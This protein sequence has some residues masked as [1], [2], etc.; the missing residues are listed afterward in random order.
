MVDRL[1]KLLQ[2]AVVFA[3][4]CSFASASVIYTPFNVALPDPP[5]NG[6]AVHFSVDIDG[7]GADVQLTGRPSSRRT[8]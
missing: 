2:I 6:T 1:A 5:H 3:F 4:C 8:W 7:G